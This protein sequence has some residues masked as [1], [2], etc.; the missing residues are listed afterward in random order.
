M[1][2]EVMKIKTHI[3]P[4]ET[5]ANKEYI[6]KRGIKIK[7]PRDL[8][9]NSIKN[10]FTLQEEYID[11]NFNNLA[12][13]K[14][15]AIPSRKSIVLLVNEDCLDTGLK[16]SDFG[17]YP[18]VLNM[19][20]PYSPGVGYYSGI[21]QEEQLFNR[22]NLQMCLGNQKKKLYPIPKYGTIYT[23]NAIVIK[24]NFV[25]K[26]EFINEIRFISFISS[27]AHICKSWDIVYFNDK[28]ILR[29][30][31]EQDTVKK[32]HSIL[33]TGIL[34]GH[35]SIILSAYGC[36]AFGNPST[37]IAKL[38]KE[39]IPEYYNYYEFIIFAI[40]DDSNAF[41]NNINGNLANFA[42]ILN[43]KPLSMKNME[44]V[45]I[46]K[47]LVNNLDNKFFKN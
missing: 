29:G 12:V 37:H 21:T 41:I 16:V 14:S 36:G 44:E 15:L 11:C 45:F 18:V 13:I 3:Y 38:F 43:L 5:F 40:I 19:A 35:D 8:I 22:T 2:D 34:M 6:N 24:E 27:A 1:I 10:T 9:D 30:T 7:I 26:Y 4:N 23:K 31:V 17:Y 47:N 28:K 32:I 33:R 42:E 39:I 20:N 25:K 46:N